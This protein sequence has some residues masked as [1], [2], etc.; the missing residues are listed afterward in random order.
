MECEGYALHHSINSVKTPPH[1]IICVLRPFFRDQPGE[2]V[3]E[4]NF[5]TLW[6]KGR[7]T[8]ADTPTIRLGT[9]PSRLTSAQLHHPPNFYWPDALPAA[10][11]TVS[12]HRRQLAHSD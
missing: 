7:P 1:H 9:T 2:L 11:P 6:C 4:E 3:P 5:C 10:Q 8:E 12:K